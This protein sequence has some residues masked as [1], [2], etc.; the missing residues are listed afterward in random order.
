V[1]TNC[2]PPPP[3]PAAFLRQDEH[4]RF[5]LAVLGI[6]VAA[7]STRVYLSVTDAG[8]FNTHTPRDS[9]M[10]APRWKLAL[11]RT[12]AGW[13]PYRR[14]IPYYHKR[15]YRLCRGAMGD[16]S[17]SRT[18]GLDYL[19]NNTYWRRRTGRWSRQAK[20]PGPGAKANTGR[21]TA[22][23]LLQW[24]RG[25]RACSAVVYRLLLVTSYG[26]CTAVTNSGAKTLILSDRLGMTAGVGGRFQHDDHPTTL[27]AVLWYLIL[28][29]MSGWAGR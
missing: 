12:T 26:R 7:A 23:G 21:W 25:L 16:A 15:A 13:T 2:P 8:V 5:R 27:V 11:G 6:P 28:L 1:R 20:I 22:D 4:R 29:R 19:A 10:V 18:D 3:P 24:F 14:A 9:G 17:S